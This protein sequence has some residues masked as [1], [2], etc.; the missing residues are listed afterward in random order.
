MV[1]TLRVPLSRFIPLGQLHNLPGRQLYFLKKQAS[2]E[3]DMNYLGTATN[4]G[5]AKLDITISPSA[6]ALYYIVQF[7]VTGKSGGFIPELMFNDHATGDCRT[8]NTDVDTGT[9]ST[10]TGDRG[11]RL[12]GATGSLDDVGYAYVA[13]FDVAD[14]GERHVWGFTSRTNNEFAFQGTNAETAALTKISIQDVAE[15]ATFDGEIHVWE[16]TS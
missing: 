12:T 3:D 16:V 13:D 2:Q 6:G 1:D 9:P 10:S 5:T 7:T 8:T 4:S 14:I 11:T 15:T